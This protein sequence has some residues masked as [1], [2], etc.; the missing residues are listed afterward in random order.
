ML[1]CIVCEG[2]LQSWQVGRQNLLEWLM[3]MQK[4]ARLCVYCGSSLGADPEF[5]KAARELGSA[6][7][8]AGIELVYG[9]GRIGLMGAIAD[10]VL[11]GGGRVTGIIPKSLRNVE[12]AHA[13]L[14]ELLTVGSMHERKRLMAERSDA[15]AILPG[16]IGTL[17][18]AFEIVTWRQ[19]HLHE[20]PIYLVDVS[21]YWQPLTALLDH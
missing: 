6:L 20:K 12:L 11:A 7:A 4:I 2:C 8:Q 21:G 17:D 15:F 9:G 10:A 16:G 14:T 13:G 5:E 18:E 3:V 19:L 1:Y